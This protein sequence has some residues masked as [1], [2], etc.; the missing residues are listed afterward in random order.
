[1]QPMGRIIER[2]RNSNLGALWIHPGSRDML[3]LPVI[4]SHL[5]NQ[6][7]FLPST[8]GGTEAQLL[9]L[10][11]AGLNRFFN[12]ADALSKSLWDLIGR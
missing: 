6:P 8:S 10:Q 9:I 4:L 7:N 11:E 12:I 2:S 1:M 5:Q 3:C